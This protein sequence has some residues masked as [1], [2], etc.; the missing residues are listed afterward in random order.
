MKSINEYLINKQ[1]KEK[2]SGSQY[3]VQQFIS[4]L[5]KIGLNVS[6]PHDKDI[7][8]GDYIYIYPANKKQRFPYVKFMYNVYGYDRRPMDVFMINN[9]EDGIDLRLNSSTTYRD[10]DIDFTKYNIITDLDSGRK[11]Y[12]LDDKFIEFFKILFKDY[13]NK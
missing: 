10:N 3:T 7:D 6:L 9:V 13:L 12:F 8:F 11:I 5:R 1:T 2:I 4:E